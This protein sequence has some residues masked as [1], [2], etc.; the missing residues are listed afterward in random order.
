MAA[1]GEDVLT[2]PQRRAIAE[3]TVVTN[4]CIL[5]PLIRVLKSAG[6]WTTILCVVTLLTSMTYHYV[7]AIPSNELFGL[8]EA[9]RSRMHNAGTVACFN[10]FL[11]Y[12]MRFTPGESWFRDTL[13]AINVLSL[14]YTIHSGIGDNLWAM[15]AAPIAANMFL[16][17]MRFVDKP[18]LWCKHDVDIAYVKPAT[19]SASLSFL[20]FLLSTIID[21]K[22]QW[23]LLHA[24][25]HLMLGGAIYLNTQFFK[26]NYEPVSRVCQCHD[27]PKCSKNGN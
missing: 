25:W 9:A 2:L 10:L 13:K 21:S 6:Y 20:F 1:N 15:L 14:W 17:A 11:V 5:P 16:L 26:V 22:D 3:M 12:L 24:G 7:G 8:N 18:N 4:L 27:V 23:R 19:L